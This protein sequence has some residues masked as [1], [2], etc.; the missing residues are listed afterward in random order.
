MPLSDCKLISLPKVQ[1]PRGNLTFIEGQSHVP[2]EI[3]RV[4]YL[5]DIPTG[6][7]RGAHA[8]KELHQFLICL[9]GSFDVSLDDGVSKQVV[10]L[11]RPWIGLHIPPMIWASEINFDPGSV[12]L[13]L[14]STPYNEADYYRDYQQF[15]DA[16]RR[17]RTS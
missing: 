8:H 6:E 12:C 13:V 5:Y 14:A 16:V 1:D 9:S 11:N 4:F 10:H 2:F 17:Q 15:L 3:K 7:D